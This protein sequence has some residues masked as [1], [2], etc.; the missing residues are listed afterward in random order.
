MPACRVTA[1]HPSI[2]GQSPSQ[3]WPMMLSRAAKSA[4]LC[5]RADQEL[6]KLVP[7]YMEVVLNASNWTSICSYS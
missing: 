3:L 6:Y 2:R 7:S 5:Y 1:I 4:H